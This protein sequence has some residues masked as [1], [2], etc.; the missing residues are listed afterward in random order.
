MGAFGT[1][2]VKPLKNLQ[3]KH[4]PQRGRLQ[5]TINEREVNDLIDE[6]SP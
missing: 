3:K 1:D 5:S 4:K 2:V 6:E